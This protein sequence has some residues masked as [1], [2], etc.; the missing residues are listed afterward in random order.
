MFSEEKISLTT[1][2][3]KSNDVSK[4]KRMIGHAHGPRKAIFMSQNKRFCLFGHGGYF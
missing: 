4:E 3:N 1:L 2:R